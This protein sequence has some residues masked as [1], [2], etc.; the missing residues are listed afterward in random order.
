MHTWYYRLNALLTF[1]TTVLAVMC[2]V[3]SITE[4]LHA[5]EPVVQEPI[6]RIDGLAVRLVNAARP[7]KLHSLKAIVTCQVLVQTERRNDRAWLTLDV[8][9]DLRSVFNWNTK[10]VCAM[11]VLI[12][13]CMECI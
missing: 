10:Q 4:V 1:A 6:A 13:S 12:S 8:D 3:A 2:A 5:S 7:A 11:H 9:A